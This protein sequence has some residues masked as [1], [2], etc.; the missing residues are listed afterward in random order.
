MR[1]KKVIFILPMAALVA[2]AASHG[3][4]QCAGCGADYNKA[5]RETAARLVERQRL[6]KID[7][8]IEKDPLGNAIIGGSLTGIV[9]GSVGATANAIVTGTA[10]GAAMQQAREARRK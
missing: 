9:R 7:P 5:D 3:Y 8:P 10:A 2:A 4:A 1:M 6:E